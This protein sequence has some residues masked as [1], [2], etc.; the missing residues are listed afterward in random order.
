MGGAMTMVPSSTAAGGARRIAAHRSD[1]IR[2]A[3]LA[4]GTF[5]TRDRRPRALFN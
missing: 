2:L 4:H 3:I 1:R 5:P